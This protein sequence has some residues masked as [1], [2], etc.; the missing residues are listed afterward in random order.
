M[1][2]RSGLTV[3][4]ANVMLSCAREQ[5]LPP[6]FTG[7]M[8]LAPVRPTIDWRMIKAEP[9]TL[10]ADDRRRSALMASAQSGDGMKK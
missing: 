8:G 5:L 2:G 7:C 4:Q 1:P 3:V 10:S 9:Q 6:R